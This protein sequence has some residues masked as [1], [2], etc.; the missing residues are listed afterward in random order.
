MIYYDNIYYD[1]YDVIY[2]IYDDN[3]ININLHIKV[4]SL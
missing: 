3:I 1:I 2:D 4:H